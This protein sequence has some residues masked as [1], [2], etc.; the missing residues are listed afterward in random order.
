[1]INYYSFKII[2]TSK[3]VCKIITL[4]ICFDRLKSWKF[5]CSWQI[6]LFLA[7]N[8]VKIYQTGNFSQMYLAKLANNLNIN[9]HTGLNTRNR[10][11]KLVCYVMQPSLQLRCKL[12]KRTVTT[13]SSQ[14]LL[15][16][17]HAFSALKHSNEKSALCY[18]NTNQAVH[19][20]LLKIYPYSYIFL[21]ANYLKCNV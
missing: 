13:C 12:F 11:F 8:I 20:L 4:K 3:R 1:M 9:S 19:T 5:F 10:M 16:S 17:L 6:I 21:T 7:Y 18:F 14:Q 15:V 2:T